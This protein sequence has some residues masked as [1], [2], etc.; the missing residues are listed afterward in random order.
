MFRLCWAAL[1]A[2][3]ALLRILAQLPRQAAVALGA[4]V[5]DQPA[6]PRRL[7]I[8]IAASAPVSFAAAIALPDIHLV[9]T[10]SIDAWLVR[11]SPGVIRKGDLV[12]FEL[13]HAALGPKSVSATKYVLCLPGERLLVTDRS[14]GSSIEGRAGH[15]YCNGALIGVSA[16]FGP[17]GKRLK[18]A[19]WQGVIPPG[20]AYVG[21]L[22][23]R[24]FDSRY[25]GLVP[26]SNLRRMQRLV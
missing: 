3:R 25:I 6:R 22:H 14:V 10:P 4:P 16:P 12:Q 23:P 11:P 8:A 19:R 17:G 5:L 2:V 20:F 13:S 24:G 7:L 15:F 1:S 9:M 21:S 18:Y 26:L